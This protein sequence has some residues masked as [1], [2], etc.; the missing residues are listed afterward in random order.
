MLIA[1]SASNSLRSCKKECAMSKRK[2]AFTLIELLVVI[3]IIAL[4]VS[5]LLPALAGARDQARQL[6]CGTQLRSMYLGTSLYADDNKGS[7]PNAMV[8]NPEYTFKADPQ[9]GQQSSYFTYIA[10]RYDGTFVNPATGRAYPINLG[11]LY[12]SGLIE[13]PQMFYCP[14]LGAKSEIHTLKWYESG[15]M[16]FGDN[17]ALY[18][19]GDQ[20]GYVRVGYTF[21]KYWKETF[22]K[23]DK[24][25]SELPLITDL[26]YTWGKASHWKNGHETPKGFGVTWGDGHVTFENANDN[27]LDRIDTWDKADQI[28]N[29][30]MDI[31]L[32]IYY[33]LMGYQS[34]T[35]AQ[36]VT[37]IQQ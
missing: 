33:R 3:S 23:R 29:N 1:Y 30:C 21:W 28:G 13:S 4:L 17:P 15:N 2:N 35:P 37:W 5:I 18:H 6:M 31:T 22:N 11:H 24:L 32:E 19:P 10:F 34:M 9:H 7:I 14:S 12:E 26:I 8:G 16:K 27:V 36:R 25:K 20:A